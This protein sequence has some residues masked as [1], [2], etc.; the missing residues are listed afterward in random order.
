MFFKIKKV[1]DGFE[2]RYTLGHKF[3][4]GTDASN[5]FLLLKNE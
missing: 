3:E 1:V 5:F 4:K 2:D